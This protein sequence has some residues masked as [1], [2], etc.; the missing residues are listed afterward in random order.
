MEG[1]ATSDKWE[2]LPAEGH[3]GYTEFRDF[4]IGPVVPATTVLAPLKEGGMCPS[5]FRQRVVVRERPNV[6]LAMESRVLGG[7]V[8]V[9][10]ISAFS[11]SVAQIGTSPDEPDSGSAVPESLRASDLQPIRQSWLDAAR[12]L[13]EAAS[14]LFPAPQ[15]G[16]PSTALGQPPPIRVKPGPAGP[17]L[18]QIR[19]VRD[20]RRQK[21]SFT[22]IG[23]AMNI[24][25]STA[26]NW[27][28]QA[29]RVAAADEKYIDLQIEHGEMR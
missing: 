22:N 27:Y 19:Q 25:R 12:R 23:K 15:P 2:W 17:T 20:L 28:Q 11:E 6:S 14:Q 4:A 29:Y 13:A 21:V 10:W 24:S 26:H 18:E 1:R 16:G 7:K 9:W 3:A 8:I 5:V